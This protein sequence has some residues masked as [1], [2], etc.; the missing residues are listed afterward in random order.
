MKCDILRCSNKLHTMLRAALKSVTALLRP[1]ISPLCYIFC[2][3]Y[4]T[5]LIFSLLPSPS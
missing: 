3:Y 4:M 1:H 2:Q 5:L